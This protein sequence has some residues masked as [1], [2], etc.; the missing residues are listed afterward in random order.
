MGNLAD[1]EYE[2]SVTYLYANNDNESDI[3]SQTRNVKQVFES[4]KNYDFYF[5]YDVVDKVVAAAD[6]CCFSKWLCN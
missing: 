2:I 6:S 1:G 3:R 5:D 4:G